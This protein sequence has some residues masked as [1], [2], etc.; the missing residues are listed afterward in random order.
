MQVKYNSNCDGV[1]L[2]FYL[3]RRIYGG[4]QG[5]HAFTPLNFEQQNI[6]FA[7]LIIY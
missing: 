7:I 4:A 2:E 6:F 1:V 3:Q 5:V